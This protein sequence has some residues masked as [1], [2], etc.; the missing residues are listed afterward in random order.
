[1][2]NTRRITNNERETHVEEENHIEVNTVLMKLRK[3]FEDMK[4]KNEEEVWKLKLE[5]QKLKEKLSE[6]EQSTI[7]LHDETEESYN[8]IGSHHTSCNKPSHNTSINVS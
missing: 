6:K 2:V 3:E 8:D 5:N 1:M 4:K 7:P